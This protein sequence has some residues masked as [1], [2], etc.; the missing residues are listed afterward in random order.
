[1]L[2]RLLTP[3]LLAATLAAPAF[4]ADISHSA[5]LAG[6]SAEDYTA[7]EIQSILDARAAGDT[8]RAEVFLT[9]TNRKSADVGSLPA[10][11]QLAAL[12]GVA[13]GEYTRFEAIQIAAARQAG[14]TDRLDFYL[15]HENRKTGAEASVVTPVE[16]RI[17]A[18]LGVDPAEY[19]LAQLYS[20][21]AAADAD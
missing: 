1:M 16:A 10:E 3:A 6:V 4:A 9:H 8:D 20:L 2:K 15:T 17:A 12:A 14:N 19:T 5:A 13:P 18:D 7:A 21:Q 11:G